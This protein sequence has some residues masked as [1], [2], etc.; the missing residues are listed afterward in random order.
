MG[1]VFFGIYRGIVMNN[2][3]P[4]NLMRLQVAVPSVFGEQ[5]ARFAQACFPPTGTSVRTPPVGTGVWILF[6]AGDPDR[7]VW[8]GEIDAP[9]RW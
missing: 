4:Q 2:V 6:E 5:E 8:I 7:P 3:D 9:V 1:D